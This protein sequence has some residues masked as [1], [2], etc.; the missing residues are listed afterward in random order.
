M[1]QVTTKTVLVATHA[2]PP[3]TLLRPGDMAW[4][5]KPAG[6]VVGANI[7][8]GTASETDF[9]GAATRRAFAAREPLSAAELAKPGDR[10]FLLA[11]LGKG[12]RA[13]SINVDAVQS[14]SGLALPGDHVDVILTQTFAATERRCR[15]PDGRRDG[16]ARPSRHRC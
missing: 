7:V 9:I 1:T 8:Q 2:M 3:G 5:E 16:V 13:V 6:T 15:A 4:E 12:Y 10:E 11:A 14:A